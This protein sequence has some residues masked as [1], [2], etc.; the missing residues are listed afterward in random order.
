VLPAGGREWRE[1]VEYATSIALGLVTGALV[2]QAYASLHMVATQF[3]SAQ[4][5]PGDLRSHISK[6]FPRLELMST[7][8]TVAMP[9]FTGLAAVYTGIRSLLF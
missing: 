4:F 7:I 2:A 9:V 3:S 8:F 1:D 5:E 6:A